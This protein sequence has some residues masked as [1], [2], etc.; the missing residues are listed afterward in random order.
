MCRTLAPDSIRS[1]VSVE[2]DLIE[3]K[4]A[5]ESFDPDSSNSNHVLDWIDI[6]LNYLNILQTLS[7][8]GVFQ[9]GKQQ[10]VL[11]ELYSYHW[12]IQEYVLP[13][14]EP[15]VCEEDALM[16]ENL[17]QMSLRFSQGRPNIDTTI[18]VCKEF[19]GP[20]SKTSQS[21][22]SDYYPSGEGEGGTINLDELAV[23]PTYRTILF[24]LRTITD[25]IHSPIASQYAGMVINIDPQV[26]ETSNSFDQVMESMKSGNIDYYRQLLSLKTYQYAVYYSK[27]ATRAEVDDKFD[28]IFNQ[29]LR[30]NGE[31]LQVSWLQGGFDKLKPQPTYR[32][33]KVPPPS[34]TIQSPATFTRPTIPTAAPPPPIPH[35]AVPPQRSHSQ[36]ISPVSRSA[37]EPPLTTIVPPTVPPPRPRIDIPVAPPPQVPVA[38]EMPPVPAPLVLLFNYGSTCYIDSMLQCLFT[39]RLFREFFLDQNRFSSVLRKENHSL[40]IGFNRLFTDFMRANGQY[41]IK[42]VSFLRLCSQLKPDLKIPTEQQDTSQF[43]YF[44][45]DRLHHEMRISDTPE[46]RARFRTNDPETDPFATFSSRKEYIKWH[47]ALLK[48]E[49]V[50]PINALFQVQ[51]ET[52]LKCG[53]CG[54]KSFNYDY[55]SMLHLNLDGHE[56]HL[57]DLIMKNLTVEELSDRLG[58]AWNCPNCEKMIK[59][60][61]ELD[62]KC[63]PEEDAEA[64]KFFKLKRKKKEEERGANKDLLTPEE[65]TEYQK[66]ASVIAKPSISFRSSAFIKLPKMLVIYLAKFDMYQRKL[67]NVSLRFPKGLKFRILRDGKEV[68]YQYRLSSWI[69]HLGSSISSGHYTAIVSRGEFWY[70]S[71]DDRISPVNYTGVEEVADSNGYLLFYTLK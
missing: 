44:I 23:L 40:T 5:Q 28:A 17:S 4:L 59:R 36:P 54:H 7:D 67:A 68:C 1:I 52:C 43:L 37:T 60:L 53:R 42:P 14:L 18:E 26:I 24:D 11:T 3:K 51:Q 71:D 20:R 56:H 64:H 12:F 49:G 13:K 65:Y 61:S 57:N 62:A 50:S 32:R 34:H 16:I 66:L 2:Y 27:S 19:I 47:T 70:Y 31:N 25:F 69:D 8:N 58:N 63:H 35:T 39:S 46:N 30:E 10:E 29:Y 45:M 22:V 15:T 9:D 55:S 38:Y 6:S 21:N 48:N 33:P 41:I